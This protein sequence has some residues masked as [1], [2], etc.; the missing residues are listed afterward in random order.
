MK[1][2]GSDPFDTAADPPTQRIAAGLAKVGLVL[3]HQAWRRAGGRGLSPTQAQVLTTL[4]HA[5]RGMRLGAVADRLA[6]T[7]ATASEAVGALARKGLVRKARDVAD[8][9]A[10]S[11]RLT[12]AGRRAAGHLAGWPD[13]LL[14][15]VDALGPDEQAVFLRGLIKMIALLQERGQIPVSQMCVTCRFF[16]PHVYRNPDRPHHCAFVGAPFGDRH[17]RLD[18]PDHQPAVPQH[19]DG[20]RSDA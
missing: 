20:R 18:C 10:I 14:D 19:L 8:S 3:K 9:R 13:V 1:Y 12:P 5:P 11:I 2:L 7:S 16:R 17:L 15:A 4:R 6:V